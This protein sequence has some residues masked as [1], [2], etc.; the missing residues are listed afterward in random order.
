MIAPPFAGGG[1][2]KFI[3]EFVVFG[4]RETECPVLVV[5]VPPFDW[6]EPFRIK[7]WQKGNQFPDL[8]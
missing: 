5:G 7:L 4:P 8:P 1:L 2:E 3:D 6:N